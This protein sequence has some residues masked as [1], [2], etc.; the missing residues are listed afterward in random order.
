[1]KARL[2]PSLTCLFISADSQSSGRLTRATTTQVEQPKVAPEPAAPAAP[3]E[4]K[5]PKPK[6]TLM[7]VGNEK[8]L[9]FFSCCVGPNMVPL[10][11]FLKA[12]YDHAAREHQGS[13]L[14]GMKKGDILEVIKTREDGWCKVTKDGESGWAPTS[15]LTPYEEPEEEAV[16]PA[17]QPPLPSSEDTNGGPSAEAAKVVLDARQVEA[18]FV[19][20]HAALVAKAKE[21]NARDLELA[22]MS[23]AL[24]RRGNGHGFKKLM[25]GN[26]P[27]YVLFFKADNLG[28]KV[29][30]ALQSVLDALAHIE[31]M[32]AESK[33]ADSGRR[34]EVNANLLQLANR[35]QQT[36]RS[37]ID[38][39]TVIRSELE[40][41]K[42]ECRAGGRWV[43]CI[44]SEEV[45]GGRRDV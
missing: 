25:V 14:M 12:L 41:T 30:A 19:A 31:R 5:P 17:P 34:L 4:K 24:V 21:I 23:N 18:N 22:L 13:T 28:T 36:M 2:R 26:I 6:R 35:L 33:A 38:A 29:S 39:A 45:G 20:R 7:K 40:Q 43:M 3:A 8:V 10:M 37:V 27:S 1:M 42:G 9:F 11:Q 44:E 16:E 15:Y 32:Q